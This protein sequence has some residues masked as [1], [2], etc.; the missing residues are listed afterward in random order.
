MPLTAMLT[1]GVAPPNRASVRATS[2]SMAPYRSVA[3]SDERASHPVGLLVL[4]SGAPTTASGHVNA[5]VT[6]PVCPC[7]RHDALQALLSIIVHSTAAATSRGV[8]PNA[9]TGGTPPTT[10]ANRAGRATRTRGRKKTGALLRSSADVPEKPTR[11][12]LGDSDGIHPLS[13]WMLT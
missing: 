1:C 4:P 2:N 13:S 11:S 3:T 8:T 12:S 10:T 7:T 9:R 6:D 5:P